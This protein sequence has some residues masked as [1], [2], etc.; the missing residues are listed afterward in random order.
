M[1]KAGVF[2][3]LAAAGMVVA[4]GLFAQELKFDGYVNSGVG[5]VITDQEDVDP[6]LTAFGVDSWQYGY[7]FRLNGAY[8][9]EAGNAGARFRFQSQAVTGSF[10]SIPYAYG[11][12]KLLGDVVTLSGGLVDDSTWASSGPLLTD[13]QSEGL[14]ALAKISPIKG[15]DIGVGAYV[16][17]TKG[18]DA[19]QT[20]ALDLAK[21]TIDLDEAKYTFNL[22]YTLPDVVKFSATYRTKNSTGF[23]QSSRAIVNVALLAVQNLTAVLEAELDNLQDFKA[24]KAG[25]KD[26]WDN[27]VTNVTG[28]SGKTNLYETIGYKLGDLGLGLNAIQY[29]SLAKDTDAG[30]LFNP[31]VSYAIGSVVPRLDV[32]YLNGGIGPQD[33][34]NGKGK[35]HRQGSWANRYDSDYSLISFRPSVKFNLD[36]K[37]FIEVGDLV[38]IE[39]GP[40]NSFGDES[41]RITNVFYI[42][43]KWTF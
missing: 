34:Q 37:T 24:L 11:W 23:S 39:N 18:G 12:V 38:G 17:S 14:G 35:Y 13:D 6:Y 26:A 30:L 4:G 27:P 33:D 29:I 8:T 21:N 43:F 22:G 40:D 15:L 25:D 36:P 9:N 28:S 1:K 10:F 32:V 42:D 2:A 19:N 5:L 31:W 20:L 16:I 7:R 3:V 41:S